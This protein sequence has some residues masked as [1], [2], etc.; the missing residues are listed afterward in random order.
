[1]V[2]QLTMKKAKRP[3]RPKLLIAMYGASMAGKSKLT[4]T[5]PG[6]ILLFDAGG[7]FMDQA[8]HRDDVFEVYETAKENSQI[9]KVTAALAQV[10]PNGKDE[11]ENIVYDDF[12]FAF[13]T[14]VE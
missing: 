6:S 1:M 2:T 4:A 3:D 9:Q 5:L 7:R 12:T 10:M 14:L 11:I 8:A 13:Q